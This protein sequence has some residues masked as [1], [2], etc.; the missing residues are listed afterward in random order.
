MKFSFD[1]KTNLYKLRPLSATWDI[2]E[3]NFHI[4]I[5]IPKNFNNQ[6]QCRIKTVNSIILQYNEKKMLI[7]YEWN[8]KAAG[9]ILKQVD[10]DTHNSL[11]KNPNSAFRLRKKK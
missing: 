7:Q 8:A 10:M 2:Q 6:K 5:Y 4:E 11:T 3:K 9:E 1:Q